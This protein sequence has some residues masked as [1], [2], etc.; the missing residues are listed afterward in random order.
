MANLLCHRCGFNNPPGMRFCGN[1][2]SQ[3]DVDTSTLVASAASKEYIPETVGVMI[4]GDLMERF[5]VAGLNAAG[6]RRTV[7]ILFADLSGFTALS[8]LLDTEE[9]FLVIQQ[10]MNLLIKDVYKYDGMVD[11][12]LGDGLMAIFGA[13]IAHENHPELAVRAADEM[14]NDVRQFSYQIHERYSAKLSKEQQISM[15]IALHSG[16]VIVGGIGSNMLLNYT[17]IGDTVNLTSR[18]LDSA[19]PGVILVSKPVYQRLKST[20]E[21]RPAGPFWL[22]GYEKPVN[23]YQFVQ[24][25]DED[26][27]DL[28]L[29]MRS[30]IVGREKQL[31]ILTDMVEEVRSTNQGSLAVVYGEAGIGKS[32]LMNEFRSN[33]NEMGIVSV[34]GH[35]YTYKKSIQYWVLQDILRHYFNL[36]GNE[37][38]TELKEIAKKHVKQHSNYSLDETISLLLWI[39]GVLPKEQ[40]QKNRFSYLDPEQLQREIF[41]LVRE[42][43]FTDATELPIVFIFEDM[44]W[45]DESS[46][47]FLTYLSRTLKDIPVFII[48]NTR[49]ISDDTFTHLVHSCQTDLGSQFKLIEM[50]RLNVQDANKL[51]EFFLHPHQLPDKLIQRIIHLGNGNPYFIEELIRTLIEQGAIQ[52]DQCW[53]INTDKKAVVGFNIPDTLQGLILSRFDRLSAVQRRLLQVASIIGRDF[54]SVVLR[55]VL[56]IGEPSFFDEILQQL[57]KRGILERYSDFKGQDYRFTH[58]LMSDTIYSTLLS[59]DKSEL[60]GMIAHTIERLYP[61]HLEELVDVLARHYSYSNDG[62]KALHY[63]IQAGKQSADKYAIVQAQKYFRH[64]ETLMSSI[65]HQNTQASDVYTGLASIQVFKGEYQNALDSYRKAANR[66][67]ETVCNREDYQKLARIHRLIAEVFEKLGKYQEAIDNITFAQDLLRMNGAADPVEIVHQLHDLGWI[68]FRLGNL[69]AAES[70]FMTALHSLDVNK[71]PALFASICNRLAGV[72]FQQSRFS[73]A[74]ELLQRSIGFREKIGDK[75]SVTRSSNNLGLLQ[76]KLGQWNDALNSFQTS[77]KGHQAL[78]DVEGEVDVMSNLGLLLIDR[79]D[80]E[81]AEDYLRTALKHSTALNLTYHSAMVCLHLS[82][83][84]YVTERYDQGLDYATTGVELF[85]AIHSKEVLADLKTWE[86]LLWVGKG[87]FQQARLC[88][89]QAVKLADANSGESNITDD[90]GRAYRLLSLVAYQ[91]ED[92]DR[93]KD[94][95]S[96]S[97]EIFQHT[98]DVL[99]QGRNLVFRSMIFRKMGDVPRANSFKSRAKQIFDQYGAKA[100]LMMMKRYLAV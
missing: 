48:A 87:E 64:A 25:V 99:E 19:D 30:P 98:G 16:E 23:A 43:L 75:I 82:K 79:G 77:L 18:L 15:H 39:L 9:V 10:F 34:A 73:E 93:A 92:I 80:F 58:I 88:G 37:T 6:Q 78:G 41:L 94:C 74:V 81:K 70:T 56:R 97:D 4:G 50:E 26:N 5:R 46:I 52:F 49:T 8:Q 51:I 35:C 11:K 67:Q 27:N 65:P 22:K 60:H 76:W 31:A 63:N 14:M 96:L 12:M 95:L 21:F 7:T 72:Y 66:L 32:R 90:R 29:R 69:T 28:V 24:I 40:F 17:A 59:G 2:G 20:M 84:Y 83:L 1:C 100:D 86:G 54:N 68:H 62:V 44:H 91:D 61:D 36:S 38:I 42:I 33:L 71:Q 53:K 85:E 45:A 47:Q 57:L 13:P 3:L 89:E 55:D